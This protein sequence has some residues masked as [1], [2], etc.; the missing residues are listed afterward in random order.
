MFI[1]AGG[2]PGGTVVEGEF[3]IVGA[4]AAG[5]TLAR[6]LGDAGRR[7]VLLESGGLAQG[8]ASDDLNRGSSVGRPM[9]DL[10]TC[11]QRFFG[12]TT[13]HWGGWCLPQDAIDFERG[14]PIAG[15]VLEPFYRAAHPVLQL[16]PFEYDLARWGV[17][18][19]D[20]PAPF[21]GPHLVARMLQNSP[22]TRFAETYGPGLRRSDRVSVYLDAT[23]VRFTTGADDGFVEGAEVAGRGGGR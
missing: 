21:G 6:A 23:V 16:G 1:E 22:P 2:V 12:G 18:P 5:I 4:G 11:R 7:V 14:W 17:R 9:L 8:A 10:E 19:S 3:C 15:S 20:I 13:N